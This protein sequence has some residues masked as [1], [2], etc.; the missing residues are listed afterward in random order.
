MD[1]KLRATNP[2]RHLSIL[3]KLLQNTMYRTRLRKLSI[4]TQWYDACYGI[5]WHPV[6]GGACQPYIIR[7]LLSCFRRET[8][9]RYPSRK[10]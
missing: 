2:P 8:Q 3:G 1:G 10:R 9:H 7:D 5:R 4:E 6:G